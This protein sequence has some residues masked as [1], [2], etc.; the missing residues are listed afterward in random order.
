MYKVVR[1]LVGQNQGS[2][3]SVP[4]IENVF[5]NFSNKVSELEMLGKKH[6]ADI[7]GYKKAQADLRS[8]TTALIRAAA[9]AISAY[10]V[11]TN[12]NVLMST[13]H[14]NSNKLDR[15]SRERYLSK[16]REIIDIATEHLEALEPFGVTAEQ[17][18]DMEARHAALSEDF[19]I[20][21]SK[22]V[23][24][25]QITFAIEELSRELDKLLKLGLD[26][27]MLTVKLTDKEFYRQYVDAR[28]YI[29]Y[30]A[31]HDKPSS[32]D[33]DLVF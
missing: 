5:T 31:K 12:N 8:T 16:F 30:G 11:S 25:K 17:I 9:S 2:W 28:N 29:A 27:L 32:D 22:I 7:T 24:R 23:E 20:V 1:Q 19:Y 3:E 21:R 26:Q 15:A 6:T 14:L 13:A 18:T 33:A 4:A 10:A